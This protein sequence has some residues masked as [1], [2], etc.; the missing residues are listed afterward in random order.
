MIHTGLVRHIVEYIDASACQSVSH[1]VN[2]RSPSK[3]PQR[4]A[5]VKT[6]DMPDEMQQFAVEAAFAA[7]RAGADNQEVASHI[8]NSVQDQF[9]GN[10]HCIVGSN[11]GR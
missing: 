5:E 11:F 2:L 1:C 7:I 4:R 6:T 8:R 10:W 9:P 3:M